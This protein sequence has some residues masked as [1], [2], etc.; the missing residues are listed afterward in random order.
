MNGRC[1]HDLKTHETLLTG[2]S[3][4]VAQQTAG[5]WPLA[6]N[7]RHHSIEPH[8]ILSREHEQFQENATEACYRDIHVHTHNFTHIYIYVYICVWHACMHVCLSVCVYGSTYKDAVGARIISGSSGPQLVRREG[9][10]E[11]TGKPRGPTRETLVVGA[12]KSPDKTRRKSA[13]DI[14][15][16]HEPRMSL[17]FGSVAAMG[18][19]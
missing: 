7:A 14:V 17:L 4:N 19:Q 18:L 5:D 16:F 2:P 15:R 12:Y 8:H 11:A 3:C 9:R 10:Q 13:P 6:S 1:Q